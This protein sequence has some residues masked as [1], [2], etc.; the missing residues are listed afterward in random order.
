MF[1]TFEEYLN[2]RI[3]ETAKLSKILQHIEDEDRQFALISSSLLDY[4][5]DDEVNKYQEL[6]K[7]V[8]DMGYGFIMLNGGWKYDNGTITMVPEK[9]VLISDIPKKEAIELGKKYGQEAII[10]KDKNFFGT[11]KTE[12]GSVGD[13][14]YRK[15][16]DMKNI[17]EF[18]SSLMR[19]PHADRKFNFRAKPEEEE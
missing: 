18:F 5:E 4:S 13:N 6:R 17:E 15:G 14:Y 8:K 10:F 9:S 7:D 2:G 12:D 19:E 11:I 16:I 3:D 1:V